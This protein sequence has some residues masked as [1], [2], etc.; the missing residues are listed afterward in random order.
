MG[1][2]DGIGGASDE[3]STAQVA[4]ILDAPV[5]LVVDA[6]SQARSAAALVQGFVVFD[7]RVRVAGV[8]FNNVASDSHARILRE[9]MASALPSVRLLGCLPRQEGLHLPSR[10]LGLVTAHDH[11]LSP[12]FR[13]LQAETME[14]HL[15]LEGLQAL[16]ATAAGEVTGQSGS[17]GDVPGD[18]RIAVARDAA[19]CFLYA[20]NLRLLRQAGAEAVAFSPLADGVLPAGVDGIYLPGGYPELFADTLAANEGMKKSIR[21]AV[22]AGM[23]VYAECGGFIYLS[24]GVTDVHGDPETM[25]PLVGVYP[26]TA[27]MLSRRKALGYRQVETVADTIL[28]PASTIARG[29]EFHYSEMGEMPLQ[30][31][32]RY[33][34]SRRGEDMGPEGYGIDNCL[35]SYV[36]LHFGSNPVLAPAFVASC[37][38]FKDGKG[39]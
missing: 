24:R 25:H 5:V 27:R 22:A 11:P 26:A 1:L 34:L 9:A 35:A 29:H 13:Q 36:H 2:F 37:R 28:G 19:F 8:I 4:R 20:D 18:V 10:H 23:P 12:E 39:E 31:E 33:R 7:P 21:D 17:A 14:R 32:R 6:T 38:R 30:V 16:A 3:G 15:D